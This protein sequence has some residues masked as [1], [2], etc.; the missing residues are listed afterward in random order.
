M[1]TTTLFGI[2]LFEENGDGPGNEVSRRIG[3]SGWTKRE[4]LSSVNRESEKE[5]SKFRLDSGRRR[6]SHGMMLRISEE[7][8]NR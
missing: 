5:S 2:F 1:R 7:T 6:I 4:I 3:S 8:E